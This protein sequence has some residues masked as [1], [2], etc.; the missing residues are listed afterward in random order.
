MNEKSGIAPASAGGDVGDCSALDADTRDG[1]VLTRLLDLVRCGAGLTASIELSAW[2]ASGGGE[3]RV[4]KRLSAWCDSDGHSILHWAALSGNAPALVDVLCVLVPG[5]P[6]V[7]CGACACGHERQTPLMWSAAGFGSGRRTE[8]KESAE[9]RA[10][11][12]AALLAHGADVAAQ[13]V[14]GY[15]PAIHA[16]QNNALLLLHQ[17][18]LTKENWRA[19]DFAGRTPL[20]W[21]AH[22][23]KLGV[24][25]YLTQL[26]E[27]PIENGDEEEG[28]GAGYSMLETKD[29][30]GHL[31]LARAA[32]ADHLVLVHYLLRL[33]DAKRVRLDSDLDARSM[34]RR[35]RGALLLHAARR[36]G[37]RW[38]LWGRYFAPALHAAPLRSERGGGVALSFVYPL[39]ALVSTAILLSL[40]HPHPL[41]L[42]LAAITTGAFLAALARDPG[43]LPR[44]SA[45]RLRRLLDRRSL[46]AHRRY[47]ASASVA[48]ATSARGTFA[49]DDDDVDSVVESGHGE[50]SNDGEPWLPLTD[51]AFCFA[52]MEWKRSDSEREVKHCAVCDRCVTGFDHHC[53][54]VSNC[55][56]AGNMRELLL[57]VALLEALIVTM[58]VEGSRSFFKCGRA[59][60]HCATGLKV[61]AVLD[62]P[63]LI[64]FGVF[65][66]G[67]LSVQARAAYQGISSAKFM[68]MQHDALTYESGA[69]NKSPRASH[70]PNS[71]PSLPIGAVSV[72]PSL[73]TRHTASAVINDAIS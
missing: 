52:C 21:A 31:P 23:G 41:P 1:A 33:A 34:P 58:L 71:E 24:A 13:D 56:G 40:P 12:S 6:D 22:C 28:C 3:S 48:V 57:F 69:R 37:R 27:S 49:L 15:T 65:A 54:W 9:V 53:A 4:A 30:S 66:A 61:A 5:A 29:A 2:L 20:H 50:T 16:A 60:N 62:L 67:V 44:A 38:Q 68:R 43:Y 42:A 8:A 19:A 73:R 35:A 7:R 63:L 45:Q 72:T 55:V 10:A 47:L 18:V 70:E 14:H 11:V 51:E 25:A 64:G 26:A 32:R 39:V 36:S 46:F 17:L 59:Q